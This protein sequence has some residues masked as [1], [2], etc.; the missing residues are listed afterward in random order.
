MIWTVTLDHGAPPVHTR[1]PA[2]QSVR[3]ACLPARATPMCADPLARS[4]FARLPACKFLLAC[5]MPA[6]LL[7]YLLRAPFIHLPFACRLGCN[8]ACSRCHL[9][10]T[11]RSAPCPPSF[12]SAHLT[13]CPLSRTASKEAARQ[14]GT[15]EK[16]CE[17]A[18]KEE[19]RQAIGC[20]L[21]A[22]RKG[23]ARANK[24]ETGT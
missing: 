11:P 24:I 3:L 23:R 18:G 22:G 2:L 7:A 14:L 21:Q 1:S 15:Q 10:R 5:P 6:C 8:S 16:G 20:E 17:T 12:L 9:I 19:K 4:A 13:V